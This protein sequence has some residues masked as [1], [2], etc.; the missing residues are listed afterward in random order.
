MN[1]GRRAQSLLLRHRRSWSNSAFG[2]DSLTVSRPPSTD[3]GRE[4][5]LAATDETAIVPQAP[6][7][8]RQHFWWI[9]GLIAVAGLAIR[10]ASVWAWYRQLPLALDD[11]YYYHHQARLLADGRGFANPFFLRNQHVVAP[12]AAHPPLYSLYLAAWTLLG[13]GGVTDHRVAACLL[14]ASICVPLAI[15]GRRLAGKPGGVIAA[16]FGAIYPPLWINDGLLLS[17]TLAGVLVAWVIVAALAVYDRPT[18]RRWAV[19]GGLSGL[20]ALSRSELLGFVFVLIIP[21]AITVARRPND[22][23]HWIRSAARTATIGTIGAGLV[24]GFSRTQRFCTNSQRGAK[25][26]HRH[27]VC[28]PCRRTVGDPQHGH[29]R[30]SDDAVDRSRFRSRNREL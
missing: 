10:L 13:A 7:A 17:E 30:T 14:G 12:S 6:K 4:S 3:R 2:V 19:L 21:L 20:A 24:V 18:N 8:P 22:R 28:R 29:V 23:S 25:G 16:G 15:V 27:H 1:L 5:S 26:D 9:V 11:N